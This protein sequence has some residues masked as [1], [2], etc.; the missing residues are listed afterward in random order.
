MEQLKIKTPSENDILFTLLKAAR[1]VN[2]DSQTV[3]IKWLLIF[4][5]TNLLISWPKKQVFILKKNFQKGNLNPVIVPSF[6]FLL[7]L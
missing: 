1:N 6:L 2:S 5:A 4:S 7:S 3:G